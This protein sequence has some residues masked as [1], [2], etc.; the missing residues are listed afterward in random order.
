MERTKKTKV[1]EPGKSRST[2]VSGRG[3]KREQEINKD[4]VR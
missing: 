1:E 4:H 2:E 3:P